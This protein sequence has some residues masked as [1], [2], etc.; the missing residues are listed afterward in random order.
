CDACRGTGASQGH[1]RTC[2]ECGGS[3][4]VAYS[5]TTWG[6]F[7]HTVT[8]C[9]VCEGTGRATDDLCSR[10]G[11]AGRRE[12]VQKLTVEIPAG[13][14]DGMELRVPRR[15]N[16]GRFGGPAGDLYLRIRIAPHPK[17][18]RRGRDLYTEVTISFPQA[19]LGDVIEV[20]TLDGDAELLIPPGTQP[21]EVLRIPRKG[22]P[23]LNGRRR[24][25]LYVT[26][27]VSVP[28][29][30]TAQQRRLLA[31]LA[32]AMNVS[33]KGTDKSFLDKVK[34]MLHQRK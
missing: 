4:R 22:M 10:C 21:N 17:F 31:E 27:K 8:T 28:K 19:A 18:Q 25:D 29:Q 26:V 16:A 15:G 34:E 13:V 30:L 3:G 11:G 24:G 20:P 23:D 33:P 9:P 7:V 5:Q 6:G 14:E 2:P 1:I 32:Q 12:G